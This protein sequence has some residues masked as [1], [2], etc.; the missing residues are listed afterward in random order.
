MTD[1][2]A[3]LRDVKDKI[4]KVEAEIEEVK[5]AL[6]GRFAD[7]GGYAGLAKENITERRSILEPIRK[8]LADWLERLEAKEKLLRTLVRKHPRRRSPPPPILE[9]DQAE[10][11][12][13]DVDPQ[14]TC[15]R[16]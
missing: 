12:I 7:A 10:P 11:S 9:A 3:E 15:I 14:S 1:F 4:A 6:V 16:C 5:A 13:P 8:D 2:A